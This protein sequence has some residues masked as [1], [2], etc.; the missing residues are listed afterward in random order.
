[1]KPCNGGA[2]FRL[3]SVQGIATQAVSAEPLSGEL[4]LAFAKDRFQPVTVNL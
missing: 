4:R 3:I 1:V 2:R